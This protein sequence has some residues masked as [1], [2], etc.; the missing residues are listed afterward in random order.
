MKLTGSAY[1]IYKQSG[2]AMFDYSM[3]D[4]GDH[5]LVAVS[6]GKDSL[7]LLQVLL[8]RKE[9][10]PIDFKLTVCFVDTGVI[11]YDRQR[12]EDYFQKCK[13]AYTIC[14]LDIPQDSDC[15][16]CSWNRRKVLFTAAR[17]QG[18]TKIALAHHQDDIIETIFLNLLFRGEISVMKP[19]LSL[20]DG[21][22][23]IIR[24]FAYVLEKD[25]ERFSETLGFT[26]FSCSCRY[27]AISKRRMIKEMLTRLG[28]DTDKIKKNIFR[29]F[30]KS[31]IRQDYLL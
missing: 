19:K 9:R 14:D 3:L 6:G 27:A 10:I 17:E 11:N 4:S 21:E 23:T 13:V 15:F 7:S 31:S 1:F 22:L 2:K 24:P 25:L 28:T 30:K 29:A 18:C 20:F 5:I 12:L 16:W 8:W 26:P